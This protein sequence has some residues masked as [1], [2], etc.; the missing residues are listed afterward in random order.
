[1]IPQASLL[2][3]FLVFAAYHRSRRVE[4]VAGF[5]SENPGMSR[6]EAERIAGIAIAHAEQAWHS[7]LLI[8]GM[9]RAGRAAR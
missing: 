6:D 9:S 5:Q 2:A 7:V 1:M 8:A 4:I 3:K